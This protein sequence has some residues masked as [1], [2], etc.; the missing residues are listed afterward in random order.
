M[1]VL[2]PPLLALPPA[3]AAKIT[4]SLRGLIRRRRNKMIIQGIIKSN[5]H[6]HPPPCGAVQSI[7]MP[8]CAISKLSHRGSHN[9]NAIRDG[10]STTTYSKVDGTDGSL[11]VVMR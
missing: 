11:D 7:Q 3:N 1:G 6:R 10:C 5:D 9:K 8:L 4:P 2:L